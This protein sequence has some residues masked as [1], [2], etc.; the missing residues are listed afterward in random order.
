MYAWC[1]VP[2][3]HNLKLSVTRNV[4][5]TLIPPFCAKFKRVEYN[6]AMKFQMGGTTEGL[7]CMDGW[8]NKRQFFLDA[9]LL[10]FAVD[11]LTLI[12]NLTHKILSR[13]HLGLR[14]TVWPYTLSRDIHCTESDH[15]TSKSIGVIYSLWA[16]TVSSLATFNQRDQEILSGHHFF[17]D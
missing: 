5:E 6:N 16:S 10:W 17:K 8:Q 2:S 12:H 13:E 9:A 7:I 3:I 4:W 1:L 14:P 15:V 11:S